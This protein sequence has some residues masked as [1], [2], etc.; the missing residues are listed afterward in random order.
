MW[1]G[2]DDFFVVH[3]QAARESDPLYQKGHGWGPR[4]LWFDPWDWPPET[5]WTWEEA[6]L[7]EALLAPD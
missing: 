2:S 1:K 4:P 6:A 3:D 7:A 5:R